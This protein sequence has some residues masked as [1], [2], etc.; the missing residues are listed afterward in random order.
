MTLE[1]LHEEAFK[2][3][4]IMEVWAEARSPAVPKSL[5]RTLVNLSAKLHHT[6]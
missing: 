1:V 4:E 6:F 3:F 2:A 5:E